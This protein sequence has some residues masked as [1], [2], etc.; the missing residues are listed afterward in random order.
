LELSSEPG[1]SPTPTGGCRGTAW[2]LE[3]I[4]FNR[5]CE[6]DVDCVVAHAKGDCFDVCTRGMRVDT[7]IALSDPIEQANHT[8]CS[9]GED[10]F[11][12]VPCVHLLAMGAAQSTSALAIR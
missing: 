4:E 3:V 7:V 1:H 6:V 11:F 12:S 5:D 9:L 8:W 10:C 2:V